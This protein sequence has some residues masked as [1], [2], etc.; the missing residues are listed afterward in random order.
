MKILKKNVITLFSLINLCC[1]VHVS[2]QESQRYPFFVFNNGIQDEQLNTPEKQVQ[3]LK[4]LGYDGMEKKGIDGFSETLDALDKHG[5]K[6]Y[7]MYLNIDLDDEK[8]PYDKRLKEVFKRLEGRETMPWFYIT[9]KLYKPSSEENDAIAVPILQEIADMADEYGVKV[10]IYPH[11]NFWVDNVQ[12]AIRVAEKVNRRNLGIT[13]NL[14]HF[15]AD[16]GTNADK[17][18]IPMVEKAM[19]YLF[20]ISLNGAD[21]PTEAIMQSNNL[22]QHFIQPLGQGN[23][24][25]HQYLN[26]F[27]ERGF[28]GPVGLQCYSIKEEKPVHLKKSMTAWKS[29]RRDIAQRR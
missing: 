25:T 21:K 2:A 18:F 10:M 26:A 24:N 6:L 1:T 3:L 12:D 9:S 23:Y 17:A 15:L 22:W 19:P 14:C 27:I 5:L 29:F 8:Q 4:S 16:Q 28:E 11:V 7:T 13:F 20:A